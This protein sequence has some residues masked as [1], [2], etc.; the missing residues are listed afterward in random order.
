MR[1]VDRRLFFYKVENERM[2]LISGAFK[3]SQNNVEIELGIGWLCD[4]ICKTNSSF[5]FFHEDEDE[6]RWNKIRV[7]MCSYGKPPR[8]WPYY[9]IDP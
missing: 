3:I 8:T 2:I 5:D 4:Q 6:E 1:V 9:H 7:E